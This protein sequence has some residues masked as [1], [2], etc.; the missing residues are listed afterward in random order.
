MYSKSVID[1]INGTAAPKEPIQLSAYDVSSGIGLTSRNEHD[2][3]RVGLAVPEGF[4][5]EGDPVKI[6]LHT[7][8]EGTSELTLA[9][10]REHVLGAYSENPSLYF[11]IANHGQDWG[12]L[13]AYRKVA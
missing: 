4:V 9:A 6:Q 2:L 10:V 12:N 11:G 7:N 5:T 1:R 13:Q 8:V 3:P